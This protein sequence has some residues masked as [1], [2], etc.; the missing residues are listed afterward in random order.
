MIFAEP[1]VEEP[2]VTDGDWYTPRVASITDRLGPSPVTLENFTPL[3]RVAGSMPEGGKIQDLGNNGVLI[4][5]PDSPLMSITELLA[6]QNIHIVLACSSN[7]QKVRMEE[8]FL[9]QSDRACML[10]TVSSD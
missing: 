7:I 8:A 9:Y 10:P 3:L 5:Y 2:G 4:L 1:V 6:G